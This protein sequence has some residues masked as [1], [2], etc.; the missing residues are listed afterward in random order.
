MGL[1][2]VNTL[3]RR[4]LEVQ[5]Y[6]HSPHTFG[7]LAMKSTIPFSSRVVAAEDQVFSDLGDE[8]A[9]LDLK[10]GTYYGLD[11][12]GARIWNLI[13]R[14]RTVREIQ[15]VLVSEYDVDPDRCAR[16]LIALLRRLAEEGLIEVRD[17]TSA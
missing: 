14:P 15:E 10:G 13:Q 7:V 4:L 11:A 8:I 17:E 6:G 9:I 1:V 12:V 5:R 3:R 2:V 16:D